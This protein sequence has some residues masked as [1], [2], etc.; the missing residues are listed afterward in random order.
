M[1]TETYEHPQSSWMPQ[2]ISE[3]HTLCKF[4]VIHAAYVTLDFCLFR[5]SHG[6][7][8]SLLWIEPRGTK[9]DRQEVR[10]GAGGEAERVDHRPVWF[11]SGPARGGQDRL[12]E[13]A[14]GWMCE[15]LSTWVWVCVCVSVCVSQQIKY[16]LS[17]SLP[18]PE[19][20]HQQSVRRQQAYQEVAALR[21][22]LQADGADISVPP[23]C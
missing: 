3:S 14:Q 7:Q 5:T 8:R 12:P 19:C 16:R 15:C 1:A 18:D 11:W 17:P 23:C 6:K 4:T 10:P 20:T 13:L 2:P 21:H 22:G 9:Q